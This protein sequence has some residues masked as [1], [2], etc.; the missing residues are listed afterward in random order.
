MNTKVGDVSVSDNYNNDMTNNNG[1]IVENVVLESK[2]LNNGSDDEIL[3]GVEVSGEVVVDEFE[4]ECG[5]RLGEYEMQRVN[6]PCGL[7]GARTR[8]VV[9]DDKDSFRS[10]WET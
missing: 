7:S 4:R 1:D 3:V 9:F 5:V 6:F 10:M 8:H 2:I